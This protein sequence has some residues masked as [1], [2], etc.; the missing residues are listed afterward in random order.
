MNIIYTKDE[1]VE[2]CIKLFLTMKIPVA[3]IMTILVVYHES[4]EYKELFNLI[5]SIA[6]S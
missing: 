4:L 2:E 6:N 1:F 5:E 3:D